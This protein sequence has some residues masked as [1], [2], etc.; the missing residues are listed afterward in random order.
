MGVPSKRAAQHRVGAIC[1]AAVP[2]KQMGLSGRVK[3]QSNFNLFPVGK[4]LQTVVRM[5]HL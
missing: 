3:N 1:P 4:V 2:E 5:R